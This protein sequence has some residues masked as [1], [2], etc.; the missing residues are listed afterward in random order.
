MT[1][2]VTAKQNEVKKE[3]QSFHYVF[4]ITRTITFSV[5]YYRCG[6]NKHK[7]FS[8]SAEVFNRPKTDYNMCGQCQD[9]V[10]FGLAK[11]FYKKWDVLHTRDL[12]GEQ[13]NDLLKDIEELKLK[14]NYCVQFSDRH[15]N[16]SD[17]KQLS[18]QPIK[19][20]ATELILSNQF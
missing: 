13:Y 1:T 18:M 12:T 15:V 8:T 19:K 4:Q 5:Q 2:N 9:D 10:L 6:G 7:Y 3:L 11:K 20:Q 14:Y 16:F 17:C